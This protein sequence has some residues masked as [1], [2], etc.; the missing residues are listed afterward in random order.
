MGTYKT[1]SSAQALYLAW[2][3][4]T[5]EKM[6]SL[7]SYTVVTPHGKIDRTR[8]EIRLASA[9]PADAKT[10]MSKYTGSQTEHSDLVTTSH[11]QL[12]RYVWQ[13]VRN[14]LLIKDWR[15]HKGPLNPDNQR[16]P[17]QQ[18]AK[19]QLSQVHK[20]NTD[21]NTKVQIQRS[22]SQIRRNEDLQECRNH[23]SPQRGRSIVMMHSALQHH[24]RKW[25]LAQSD[26]W[27]H[28][29]ALIRSNRLRLSRLRCVK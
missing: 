21:S 13:M 1:Q 17:C 7:R 28:K 6:S 5:V 2:P 9:P 23:L 8:V 11:Q 12:R 15:Q 27:D 16:P 22:A 26:S 19:V 3:H 20:S 24:Q 18:R 4:G 14:L 25:G 29:P 10:Y